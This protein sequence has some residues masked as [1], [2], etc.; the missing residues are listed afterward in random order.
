MGVDAMGSYFVSLYF[1]IHFLVYL[2]YFY[3]FAGVFLIVVDLLEIIGFS[4]F[5]R[6]G[7]Q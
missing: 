1:H 2:S 3:A 6:S 4:I 5:Q 7:D